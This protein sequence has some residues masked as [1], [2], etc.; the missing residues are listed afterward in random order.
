M[1]NIV[2]KIETLGDLVELEEA[3]KV[4]AYVAW[5]EKHTNLTRAEVLAMPI[6][7]MVSISRQIGEQTKEALSIP[8][9]KSATSS[10]P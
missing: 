1:E 3:T 7:E 2:V 4:S 6:A 5:L 10:S 9:E 8:K